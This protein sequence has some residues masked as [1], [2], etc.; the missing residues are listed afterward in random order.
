MFGS[1]K[2]KEL[3]SQLEMITSNPTVKIA[4]EQAKM[5]AEKQA[6]YDQLVGSELNYT[7][8]RDL[9]NAAVNGVSISITFKSGEKMVIERD[10][11]KPMT[12]NP[13]RSMEF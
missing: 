1:K 6:L 3:E 5:A 7:I 13:Y 4:L 8:I 2:I 12:G 9:V 10:A 11:S